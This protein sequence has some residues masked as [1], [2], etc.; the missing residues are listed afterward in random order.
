MLADKLILLTGASRGIGRAVA[1]ALAAQGASVILLSRTI[2]DLESLYD[3]IV[4]AGHPKPNIC[5]FNLCSATPE[6]YD[7]L[8]RN[9]YSTY[10]RLDGLIHNAGI[11]GAL[12][13]LEHFNIQTWYQVL[14]VNLNSTLI[15]TQA[16]LPLLKNSANG[17]IIFTSTELNTAAKANWGAYAVASAGCQTMM[18]MLASECENLT[19]IRVNAVKPYKIKTALRAEAYPAEQHEDLCLPEDITSLYVYLMSDRSKHLNGRTITATKYTALDQ[20]FAAV[21]GSLAMKAAVPG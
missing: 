10:G 19:K 21:S 17:S 8:R 20:D 14:Q 12:T 18:Q 13:P 4:Q 15:L 16:T 5:P 9:I 1:K 7:D 6:D 11:L 2:K 3:E